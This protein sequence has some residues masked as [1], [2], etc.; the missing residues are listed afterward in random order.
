MLMG[1]GI[2]TYPALLPRLVALW[3]WT[4]TEAGLVGGILFLGY[5]VAS[6]FLGNLTDR[7]DARLVYLGSSVVAAGG[8]LSF[9][10][11]DNLAGALIAQALFGAG[12]AGMYMPGLK[13]LTDRL[14]EASRSR[15]SALYSSM[16]GAGLAFSYALAPVLAGSI[17]WRWAFIMTAAGAAAAGL[18][19]GAVLAPKPPAAVAERPTL[20]AAFQRVWANRPVVGY[21]AA[22]AAH[23]WELFAFRAWMVAFLVFAAHEAGAD[24]NA[25]QWIGAIAGS[26]AVAAIGW[27]VLCNEFAARLGRVPLL[28][29]IL[30]ATLAL[31]FALSLSWQLP[32]AAAAALACL[33]YL[34]ANSDA[35]ALNAGVVEAATP[36]ER[37]ATLAVYSTTGYVAGFLGPAVA[38]LVLDFAGG[39]TS[40]AAWMAALLVTA[41]PGAFAFAVLR[42]GSAAPDAATAAETAKGPA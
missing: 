42:R 18:L 31:G 1:A 6:P 22:Y 10:F 41:A 9:A 40:G 3:G 39:P 23:C 30:G 16:Q 20:A 15:A 25:E 17:G 2:G 33:Y 32:F 26:V 11:A 7:I 34:S 29:G 12:F 19:A 4:A 24:S 38:G 35:G 8:L 21:V 37:G 28:L 27:S 14:A 36:A 5:V 13:A